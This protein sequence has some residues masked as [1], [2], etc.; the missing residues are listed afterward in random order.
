MIDL[1]LRAVVVIG[2]VLIPFNSAKAITLDDLI[3]QVRHC[4][5]Q[6]RTLKAHFEQR[7]YQSA[8]D[9]TFWFHGKL[10]FMKPQNLRI[11]VSEPDNQIII[12]DSS[13]LWIYIPILKQ[14]TV[15]PR[16]RDINSQTLLSILM[17]EGDPRQHFHVRWAQGDAPDAKGR[18]RIVLKPITPQEGTDKIEMAVDS[19]TY[20]MVGFILNDRLGNWQDLEIKDI[21]INQPLAPELFRMTIPEGTDVITPQMVPEDKP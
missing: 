19:K 2:L 21:K 6:I 5:A 17:G 18:Y 11:Q 15:Q 8:T 20:Y 7:N 12:V 13:R 9:N 1:L 4:Y 16:P 3:E 10:Y 14:L